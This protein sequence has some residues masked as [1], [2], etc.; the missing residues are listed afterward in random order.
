MQVFL[1]N[2]LCSEMTSRVEL[3]VAVQDIHVSVNET[4]LGLFLVPDGIYVQLVLQPHTELSHS[5]SLKKDF[6]QPAYGKQ[7]VAL[8]APKLPG[9]CLAECRF[10]DA[11]AMPEALVGIK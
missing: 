5:C 3:L 9:H 10:G 6:I 4:G 1:P 11:T 2:F 8:L 7:S